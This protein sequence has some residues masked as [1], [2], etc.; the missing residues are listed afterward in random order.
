MGAGFGSGAEPLVVQRARYLRLMQ[1]GWTNADACRE[2]GV[3]R[4]TGGR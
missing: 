2:V 3:H 4:R 1:Q